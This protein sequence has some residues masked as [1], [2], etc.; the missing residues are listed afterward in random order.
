MRSPG[1]SRTRWSTMM[2]WIADRLLLVTALSMAACSG[3][4]AR[5]RLDPIGDQTIGVGDALV[6]LVSATAPEGDELRFEAHSSD[7]DIDARTELDSSSE[8]AIFKW[9]PLAK[10]VGR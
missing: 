2:R 1:P 3:G 5:P 8:S 7:A 10:D 6:I 9:R 4:H